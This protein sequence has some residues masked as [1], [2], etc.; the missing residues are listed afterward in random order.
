LVAYENEIPVGL[1]KTRE[2]E[3]L[4][5]INE[6]AVLPEYRQKGVA[7]ALIK[8]LEM[9]AK[10]K[11]INEIMATVPYGVFEG[12]P[13][14]QELLRIYE[15]LGFHLDGIGAWISSFNIPEGLVKAR[16]QRGNMIYVSEKDLQKLKEMGITPKF[17]K[18]RN[19][20]MIKQVL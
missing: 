16:E 13:R 1:V 5:D 6:I 15:H 17:G 19:Y 3:D 11:R 18:S 9:R 2:S 14:L 20:D 4:I 12:D 7:K 10:G 8:K